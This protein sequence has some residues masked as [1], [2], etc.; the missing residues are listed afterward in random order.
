MVRASAPNTAPLETLL[1]ADITHPRPPQL[2][3]GGS[4]IKAIEVLLEHK[5]PEENIMFLN[6]VRRPSRALSSW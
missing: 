4:V 2:A 6:L 5:V 3:T 1:F